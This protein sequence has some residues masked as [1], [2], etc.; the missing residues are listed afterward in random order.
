MKRAPILLICIILI[1]AGIYYIMKSEKFNNYNTAKRLENLGYTTSEVG[2]LEDND[3][4]LEY[5]LNNPYDKNFT[6]FIKGKDFIFEKLD[7]YYDYLDKNPKVATDDI[8][9]LVNNDITYKYSDLLKSVIK[10]KYFLKSRLERYMHYADDYPS[11]DVTKVVT[12]VNCNLD[13]DYYTNVTPSDTS[14]GKLM[15]ANKYY[16]LSKDFSNDLVTLDKEYTRVAGAQLNREAYEA[17]KKLSDA[18]KEENLTI[19]SQSAYR[20]YST[21][22]A[23]YNDYVSE[24][25]QEWTDRWSARPGYSEHQT[26]LALDVLNKT[27]KSLG[28]F[29][30]TE[31]FSW[32][33]ENS[34]KYGFILRYKEET[35]MQT[36]YGYEP[37]HYRYVGIEAAK[38]IYD[39]NI[40]FDEYYAYYVLK[41]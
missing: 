30:N 13:Y 18:A 39:N 29:E 40:T 7:A 11:L 36:G 10:Q 22:L 3:K 34:Y 37:W 33:K 23:I 2:L 9:F 38:V 24:D 8:I 35:T 20:S 4:Y 6:K 27:N 14:Y 15:I 41:K 26:G 17:F 25:G 32:M 5:A 16:S 28:D 31:E 12:N 19:L 1:G 21:Q